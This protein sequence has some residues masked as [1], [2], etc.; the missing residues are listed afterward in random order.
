MKISGK[1][2]SSHCLVLSDV[3]IP[4]CVKPHH[5]SANSRVELHHFAD[6]SEKAYG[7]A[8]YLRIYDTEHVACSLIMGKA[9]LA[10]LKTISIPR[11]ELSA[12][13]VAVRLHSF[14]LRELDIKVDKHVFWTDSVSTIQYIRNRTTRFKTFVANR[15]AII[16]DVTTPADWRYVPSEINPADLASRG[17]HPTEKAKLKYW[18]EGPKFL[19][20]A[21]DDDFP[22]QPSNLGTIDSADIEAKKTVLTTNA[23]VTSITSLIQSHSCWYKLK[24]SF[25][26]LV[27][28]KQFCRV[29][30]LHHSKDL[31]KT[32]LITTSEMARAETDILKY[33]QRQ[34]YAKE[35]RCLSQ[36]NGN[37]AF[38]SRSSSLVKLSP[39]MEDGLVKVGGRL[40]HLS[41][42]YESKHQVILP[43]KC[44]VTDLI[45]RHFHITNGHV[46]AQQVLAMIRNQYWIVNG[47]AAVKRSI[48][49]CFECRRQKQPP[50]K[51]QMA[52]L[53]EE[54]LIPDRPPFTFVGLD[55]VGPL[56]VKHGRGQCKRYGC[57]FTCL[58]TR[59]VHIELAHSLDTNSFLGALNRFISRR[60]K[61]CKIFSDNGTN[62]TS[63]ER[64]LNSLLS[65]WNQAQIHEHLLQKSIEWHFIPP[66]ASHM[67]GIWERIVKSTKSIL[68]SLAKEQ[69]LSDEALL[70]FMAEAERIL[71]D[72]PITPLSNDVRDP[73]PLT[74]N[75]LLLLRCN[76]SLPLGVFT[77]HE[78]YYNRWWRQVQ[79]LANIF[80]RRWLKEYLPSL[81][82]R[83]KWFKAYENLKE[84]DIVLI[85]DE[86]NQRGH[87]PMGIITG[88]NFGRD[89]LVR[90]VKVKCGNSV[91]VRP[92]TKIC[93]LE[94]CV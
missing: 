29:K 25:S 6:G 18:I 31:L 44:H 64:E 85:V 75:M 3:S 66:S 80:W 13:V 28:F 58:T 71:N 21:N 20:A 94:G 33:V 19:Q 74:P 22:V 59:A 62:L 43:K 38:V 88:V 78:T 1:V 69:L 65:Q 60:G 41:I 73:E 4:R 17:I 61:P 93:L 53:P 86:T 15:L 32:G 89:H 27:R 37:T 24:K 10:P 7:A 49:T 16:H 56:L 76:S 39:F 45:I 77:K 30:F 34:E 50:C 51:Q 63:G 47:M 54:R 23:D 90:S 8:S 46:G 11:V 70:T 72:R 57:L 55:Y 12:A 67:D 5:L 26:W 48:G 92:V 82:I 35:I 68:K 81:Q 52:P 9:R 40:E 42:Q 91:K 36:S 14:I 2:G 83:D 84:G 87:W 79:Y